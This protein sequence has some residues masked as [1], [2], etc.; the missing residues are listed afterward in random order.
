VQ[1]L[2]RKDFYKLREVCEYTDTQPYVLRFWES[3]FPQLQPGKSASGQRLY[4]RRDID[5]VRRIKELLYEEQYTLETARQQLAV[6]L[7][8]GLPKPS[9][10]KK[11]QRGEKASSRDDRIR[12]T[13]RPPSPARARTGGVRTDARPDPVNE[14]EMVPRQRYEDA[15]DEIDHLRLALKEAEKATRRAETAADEAR[16]SAEREHERA[17][18]AIG[19]LERLL[20]LLS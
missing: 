16:E 10:T 12:K 6:E 4:R 11:P 8:R 15:V 1:E 14:V 5:L 20:D 18:K 7:D 9:R 2:P 3:E 19:H 17:E 13:G